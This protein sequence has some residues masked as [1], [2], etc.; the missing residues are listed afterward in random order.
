VD[1]TTKSE[2]HNG[3]IDA[4]SVA[5]SLLSQL[6][7][8]CPGTQLGKPGTSRTDRE[9]EGIAGIFVRIDWQFTPGTIACGLHANPNGVGSNPTPATN[10]LNGSPQLYRGTSLNKSSPRN[11]R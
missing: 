5:K 7:D 1:T 6:Y 11:Y 10:L 2:S 8:I 9:S 3:P 4:G